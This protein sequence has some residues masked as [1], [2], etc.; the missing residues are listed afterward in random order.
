MESSGHGGAAMRVRMSKDA[1]GTS[2][3]IP[4]DISILWIFERILVRLDH[5]RCLAKGLK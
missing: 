5:N 1:R 4:L 2:S 3:P